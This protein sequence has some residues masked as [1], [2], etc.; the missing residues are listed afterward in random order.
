VI[1]FKRYTIAA[2]A[3]GAPEFEIPLASLSDILIPGIL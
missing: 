2:G 1:V 3:Y